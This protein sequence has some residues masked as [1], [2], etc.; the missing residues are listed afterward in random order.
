MKE[1]PIS[2]S[3]FWDIFLAI[4]INTLIV[5]MSLLMAHDYS[6]NYKSLQ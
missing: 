5:W 3:N 2:K 1:K 4:L 6:F